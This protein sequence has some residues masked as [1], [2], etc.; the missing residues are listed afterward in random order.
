[1]SQ[2]PVHLRPKAKRTFHWEDTK[3]PAKPAGRRK[4]EHTREHRAHPHLRQIGIGIG[5][6]SVDRLLR[7]DAARERRYQRAGRK[8]RTSCLQ[9]GA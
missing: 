1:M 2:T 3:A 8:E 7:H 9:R 6:L 4:R 5:L